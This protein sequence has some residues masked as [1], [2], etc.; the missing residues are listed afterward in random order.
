MDEPFSA[1]D[2]ITRE[3]LQDQLIDIQSKLKK[4]IIFVT[5]DISEAIKMADRICLMD[6]GKIIQYDIVENI[7]KNPADDFVKGF[8]GENRI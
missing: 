1:L 6:D 8:I 7:L 4:T 2:P 3:I 5:H